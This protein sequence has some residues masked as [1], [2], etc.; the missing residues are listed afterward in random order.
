[1]VKA[2]NAAGKRVEYWEI[3]KAGHS[4]ATPEAEHDLLAR[5]IGFLEKALA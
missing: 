2:L 4:P 1:M 3:R 5:V